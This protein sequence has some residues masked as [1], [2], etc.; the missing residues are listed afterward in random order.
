MTSRD[1]PEYLPLLLDHPYLS[2]IVSRRDADRTFT[3]KNILITV[4]K[5]I[6]HDLFGMEKYLSWGAEVKSS[7]VVSSDERHKLVEDMEEYMQT[8]GVRKMQLQKC[9]MVAEELLMNAIYDAPTDVNGEHIYNHLPRTTSVHLKPEEQSIFR[10]ACDG[11]LL[12]VAVEDPFGAFGRQTILDYLESCYGG[13]AG[14][15]QDKKRKGGAGR[16]LYQIM[17]TSDLLVINVKPKVR[18]EVIA[19][20]NIDPNKPKSSQTTSFHYF[21][22]SSSPGVAPPKGISMG[23]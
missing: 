8:L 2:N 3:L 10:Y 20:F 22:D 17:E 23:S 14:E 18:T 19:V 16:G 11:M 5:L 13:R 1:V 21:I 9:S 15:M 6:T 12:A 7:P 4:S